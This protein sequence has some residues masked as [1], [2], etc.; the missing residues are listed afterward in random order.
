M[1]EEFISVLTYLTEF[2]LSSSKPFVSEV[3]LVETNRRIKSPDLDF[4][5][6]LRSIGICLFMTSNPGTNQ[7]EY[8]IKNP[9]YLFSG[10]SIS[11]NQFMSDNHFESICSDLKVRVIPYLG[12]REWKTF[13]TFATNLNFNKN[14][15]YLFVEVVFANISYLDVCKVGAYKTKSSR[16]DKRCSQ[17]Q[18]RKSRSFGAHTSSKNQHMKQFTNTV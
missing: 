11:V 14:P 13:E 10:C 5:K 2:V 18:W 4:G 17:R 15:V 8:C 9:I 16:G 7:V 1:N 3:I 6:F 12:E